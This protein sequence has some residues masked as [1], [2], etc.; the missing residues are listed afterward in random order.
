MI[1]YAIVVSEALAMASPTIKLK[2]IIHTK[3][4]GSFARIEIS[5]I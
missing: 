5:S 4:R 1:F 3:E 2:F